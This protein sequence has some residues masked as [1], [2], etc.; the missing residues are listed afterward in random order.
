MCA[1]AVCTTTFT[2]PIADQYGNPDGFDDPLDV[3]IEIPGGTPYRYGTFN[4]SVSYSK[5]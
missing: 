2:A 3:G 1:G 5:P 4:W